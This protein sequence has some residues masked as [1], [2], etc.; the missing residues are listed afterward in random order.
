[1]TSND[2]HTKFHENRASNQKLKWTHRKHG[3]LRNLTNCME[4]SLPKNFQHFMEPEGSLSCSQEP[5]TGLYFKETCF[6]PFKDECMLKMSI[7]RNVLGKNKTTVL[8]TELIFLMN[9]SCNYSIRTQFIFWT[10]GYLNWRYFIRLRPKTTAFIY[11]LDLCGRRVSHV[12]VPWRQN[13]PRS[14]VRNCRS[15]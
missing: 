12:S 11:W 3:D 2:M 15:I 7:Y 9:S 13:R 8:G 14:M 5:A 10:V 4:P 1:M 6:F